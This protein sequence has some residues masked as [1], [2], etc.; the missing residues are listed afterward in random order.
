MAS[1]KDIRYINKDFNSFKQSLI[2]YAK[3]YFP[4]AYN[5]FSPTAPGT[6]FIE[7]ASYVGDVLS[8]YLDN[9]IQETFL[10]HAREPRNL[11]ELAYMFGYKPKV[12]TVSTATVDFY[13]TIPSILSSSVYV[14]DYRY[15]LLVET[16]SI[17]N[18]TVGT[19]SVSFLVEDKIDFSVSSS[20]DITTIS[21]YTVSSNSPTR[22]LLKKSR[23]AISATVV[24]K[25]YTVGAPVDFYTVTLN[26][27]NIIKILNIKDSNNNTWYEVDYLAQDTIYD[28]IK[29]TNI[30][31]PYNSVD[32]SDTPYLLQLK[33]IQRRFTTR[34][35]DTG[36]LQ[37]QFGAGTTSFADENIIPNPDNVGLGLPSGLSKMNT[38]YSPTNFIFTNTYGI[39][40]SNTTLTVRYLVGGGVDSNVP[41]NNINR[42]TSANTKFQTVGLD[43]TTANETFASLAVT[44]PQASD[45]GSD[46]DTMDEIRQ[47]TISNFNTQQRNVT[48]D[49]YTVRA[50]SLPSDF[51]SI[52]KVYVTPATNVQITQGEIPSLDLY[53]LSYDINKNLRVASDTLKRNL[54]K[55][56]SQYRMIGDSINIKNAFV[57]NI[58]VD[59]EIITLPNY[60]SN[61]VLLNCI[62]TLKDYFSIDKWQINQPIVLRELYIL[63]DKIDG[64]QTVKSISINNKV[65]TGVD[66]SQYAYDIPGATLNNVVYPSIDPM[67]F[68]VKLP[69]EDIKGKV[70]PL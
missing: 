24:T 4:T 44:N 8:F 1:N 61:N 23:Q 6:M 58:G 14:P 36:S 43:S 67:I 11:Y 42:I 59:F 64:V 2:D 18:A 60:I 3:T 37:I 55:Y 31:D 47:N 20:S 34:V 26:D 16:G 32:S 22:F 46:G 15:A 57:V 51:G 53:V 69:N 50:L 29:N 56:L 65:G 21:V 13:Q 28:S 49:D 10:Q 40:P 38:A 19:G 62:T 48:L 27:D 54:K 30:N 70:V 35:I 45:G 41:A 25:T 33:Q 12:T 7:M 5:D 39:A 66:Y 17:L 9:Q 63:L 52:A 68:E